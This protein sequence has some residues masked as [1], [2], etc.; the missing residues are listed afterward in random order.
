MSR[1]ERAGLG[2]TGSNEKRSN[3]M[4][5]KFFSSDYKSFSGKSQ[6]MHCRSDYMRFA[7]DGFCQG[8]QQRAEFVLREHPA[9]ARRAETDEIV[10]NGGRA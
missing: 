9:V 8:C 2:G 4:L 5:N 7:V 3:T 6:C 1:N 10:V